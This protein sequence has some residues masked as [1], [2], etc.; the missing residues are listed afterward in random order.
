MSDME[1]SPLKGS[2]YGLHKA[3]GMTVLALVLLRIIWNILS[4]RPHHLETHA[5]WEV[6]LSRLIHVLLYIGMIGMPLSGWVMSSAGDHPVTFFGLFNFPA[7]VPKNESLFESS[8]EIHEITG[9]ALLASIGLHFAGAVKHHLIDRDSTLRRMGGNTLVAVIGAV[10]IAVPIV[11]VVTGE[12]GEESAVVQTETPQTAQD[13][14]VIVSS[15]PQW[16]IN[17]PSSSIGFSFTQYGQ[18]VNGSFAAFDGVIRFDPANLP[19]SLADIRIQSSSISTGDKGRDEQ[20]RGKEWFDSAA[21]PDIHF[22]SKSIVHEGDN[23]YTAAGTLTI[24]DVSKDITLPFILDVTGNQAIMKTDLVLKRL[25][26]GVGQG[27]WAA[28]DAV[29]ADVTITINLAADR[30]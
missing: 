8:K 28:V 26:F 30:S 2:V 7:I 24:R 29:G 12:E 13:D 10:L 22:V 5:P 19:E 18:A 1:Y 14:R 27:Q 15:A 25:D 20:A 9:F 3:F 23:R 16:I 11:I 17:K 21:Y 6:Y 4:A